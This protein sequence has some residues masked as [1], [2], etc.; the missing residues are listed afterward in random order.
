MT[1]LPRALM[2]TRTDTAGAEHVVFDDRRGL[3]AHGVQLAVDPVPYTCRYELYTDESWA[4]A[5]FTATTEG[6]GWLRTVR[7]E[8]A[9]GRWRVTTAEQGQLDAHQPGIED[10]DRLEGVLDIDLGGSPLTNTLP[11]KRSGMEDIRVVTAWVLPPSLAVVRAEQT[12]TV[13][14]KERVRYASDGFETDIELDEH[15]YVRDYPGLAKR[16]G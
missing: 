9:A 11:L 3:T 14:S 6:A 7:M 1:L 2:W 5:Q 13:L 10:P 8:R 4:T 12:Y 15:G 16:V